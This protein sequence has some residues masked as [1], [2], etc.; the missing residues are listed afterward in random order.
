MASARKR[1]RSGANGL[2]RKARGESAIFPLPHGPLD[3]RAPN[4][5]IPF[6]PY[7]GHIYTSTPVKLLYHSSLYFLET[8]FSFS[9]TAINSCAR[10]ISVI[11]ML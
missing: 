9:F 11:I 5:L 1:E 10:N 4:F 2:A 3:S 7:A 6:F 8:R